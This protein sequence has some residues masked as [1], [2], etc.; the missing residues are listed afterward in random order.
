MDESHLSL[1]CRVS[2]ANGTTIAPHVQIAAA[3]GRI[4]LLFGP[5]GCGKTSC[6]RMLAGLLRPDS[7]C[8]VDRHR[9]WFDASRGIHCSPQER[10][11]G[12]LFQSYALFSHLNVRKNIAYGIRQPSA[13]A[14]DKSVHAISEMLEI[15]HLLDEP[16]SSIS[17]GQAQRVAL[18]RALAPR[19][20]WL[21]LDEPMAALDEP[22]RA[23]IGEDLRRCL[24][25]LG[26][27]TIMVTHDRRELEWIG[28]D[29]IV[30]DHGRCI[31]SGT[32]TEVLNRPVS[33]ASAAI[34]GFENLIP[35]EVIQRDEEFVMVRLGSQAIRCRPSSH[36]SGSYSH[37]AIRAEDLWVLEPEAPTPKGCTIID[38]RWESIHPFG[39][40][41]RLQ[42]NDPVPLIATTTRRHL[43]NPFPDAGHHIRLA[44]PWDVPTLVN[45]SSG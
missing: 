7:G 35:T 11:V 14:R 41:C 24:G 21:L 44:I 19:P 12:V 37:V 1:D 18:A 31:Q 10:N 33:L 9:V 23:R 3:P 13:A 2:F 30:M 8:I 34:L 4:T 17:G 42:F 32:V 20:D 39:A 36:T 16:T 28:D 6:L 15:S 45:D 26:I 43:P 5:S 38:A 29:L 40:L 25:S 22:L 27:P